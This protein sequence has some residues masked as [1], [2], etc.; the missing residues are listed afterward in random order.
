MDNGIHELAMAQC[1]IER[2]ATAG[3]STDAAGLEE[4][5][6]EPPLDTE[7][8]WLASSTLTAPMPEL[9]VA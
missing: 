5:E 4:G 8:K 3:A 7:E 6:L 2:G 9:L 1:Q